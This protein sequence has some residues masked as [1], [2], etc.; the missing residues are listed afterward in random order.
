MIIRSLVLL[1]LASSLGACTVVDRLSMVGKAPPLS[2]IEARDMPQRETSL[3]YQDALQ[4]LQQSPRMQPTAPVAADTSLFRTSAK[5]FFRDQRAQRVGDILTIRIKIA[6]SAE[7]GNTTSRTRSNSESAKAPALFGL[8]SLAAGSA[9]NMDNLA[10]LNSEAK[11]S[12][13]GQIQRKDSISL[14]IA[15]IVTKVL[16]NG[17]LLVQGRQE[18]RVNFEV[19]EL[20]VAGIVRPEDITRENTIDHTQIAEA[21]VS[22]GGRG[23]LTD[24]QQ[25]RYGQQ[26]F[27]AIMPF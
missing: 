27:D 14:T 19:R 3:A 16:P 22:Y 1:A 11:S 6:D 20:I 2:D 5:A 17:N 18:V 25:A 12:G 7:V 21:R 24:V 26:V 10:T 8:E 23:Q 4:S 13:N 15:G 9:V